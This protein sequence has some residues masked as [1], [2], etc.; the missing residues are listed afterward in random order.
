ML[1]LQFKHK[2]CSILGT[3]STFDHTQ[4]NVPEMHMQLSRRVIN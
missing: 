2:T 4:L 3:D 1:I